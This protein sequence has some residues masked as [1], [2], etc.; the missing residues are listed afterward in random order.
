M[1]EMSVVC[2]TGE[3]PDAIGFRGDTTILIECKTSRSDFFA[4]RTKS[5]RQLPERGMGALRFMLA[6]A[7]MIRVDE[8]PAGWGLIEAAGKGATRVY[9]AN[10]K[11]PENMWGDFFH[12]ARAT[13][14]EARILLSGLNRIRVALGEPEFR[15]C[16]KTR[17]APRVVA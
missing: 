17:L 16:L 12:A 13:D 11:Q 6:P 10:P 5:F 14:C 2:R 15:R 8:L 1:P 3:I 9:G 7:G 4:D